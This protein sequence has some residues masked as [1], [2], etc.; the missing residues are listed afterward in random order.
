VVEPV[1]P[2]TTAA[3]GEADS[4][5]SS[6]R[7]RRRGSRRRSDRIGTAGEGGTESGAAETPET[8]AEYEASE[9]EAD[10]EVS[11]ASVSD[12]FALTTTAADIARASDATVEATIA[13]EPGEAD[14]VVEAPTSEEVTPA[15]RERRRR[16]RRRTAAD[17]AI[18]APTEVSVEP[19]A[20]VSTPLDQALLSASASIPDQP[21]DI[22][23]PPSP[24]AASTNGPTSVEPSTVE[25]EAAPTKPAT[26]PRRVA[27]AT[28]G[29]SRRP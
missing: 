2:V 15:P 13:V 24:E 9:A 19:E 4:Q 14:A 17:S 8:E 7:R 27:S 18:E 26:R 6:R 16:T 20:V 23:P 5:T 22:L 21:V 29:R 3:P 11:A 12:E 28:R 1:A 25:A 10:Y